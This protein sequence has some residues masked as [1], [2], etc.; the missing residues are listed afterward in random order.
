MAAPRASTHMTV[1]CAAGKYIDVRQ[2][3][4]PDDLAQEGRLL[5]IRFDQGE[6]N[7]RSPDFQRQAGE[8]G[9][10]TYVE[11]TWGGGAIAARVLRTRSG[12][13]RP[14]TR[15]GEEMAGGE[16]R[17]TEMSCHDMFRLAHG[18]E[19]DTRVPAQENIDI[20]RYVLQ[21][22]L[23]KNSRFPSTAAQGRLSGAK[24]RSKWQL[25]RGSGRYGGCEERLEQVGDVTRI[26]RPW[27]IVDGRLQIGEEEGRQKAEGRSQKEQVGE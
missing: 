3:K 14:H 1:F 2:C 7:F 16:E 8:A 17:L 25:F 13:I 19:I 24:A 21:L 15:I 23:G 18:S 22:G 11:D 5:V 6:V 20:H 4:S 12:G 9:S 26:H 10:R 27:G